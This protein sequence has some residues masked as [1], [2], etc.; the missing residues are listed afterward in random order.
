MRKLLQN[1]LHISS[2]GQKRGVANRN[3]TRKRRGKGVAAQTYMGV[4]VI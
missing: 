2:K 3:D 4:P 1:R